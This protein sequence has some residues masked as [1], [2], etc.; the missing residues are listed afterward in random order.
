MSLPGAS[1]AADA[2]RKATS[3]GPSLTE[4]PPPAGRGAGAFP[5]APRGVR[6]AHETGG[7]APTLGKLSLLTK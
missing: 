6:G 7:T 5:T 4:A 2:R 1:A 3:D